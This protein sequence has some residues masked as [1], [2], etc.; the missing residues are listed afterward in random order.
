M[1]K[2]ALSCLLAMANVAV[3]F[4]AMDVGWDGEL[5]FDGDPIQVYAIKFILQKL[6]DFEIKIDK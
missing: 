3:S 2:V 1:D 4:V 5:A 6:T